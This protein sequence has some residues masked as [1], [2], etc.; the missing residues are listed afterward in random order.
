M[1][2]PGTMLLTCTPSLIPCSAKAFASA[3]IAAFVAATA[4]KADFGS[5][6]A[7]PDINT[8]EPLD[9]FRA[10]HARIVSRP[11]TVQ[12]QLHTR[13]PLLIRHLEEIDLGNGTRDV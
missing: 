1:T 9:C 6:A 4:A 8:T 2:V 12:L 11:G 3:M 7:L 5:S 13:I 10:S